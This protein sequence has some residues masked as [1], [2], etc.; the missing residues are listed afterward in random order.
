MLLFRYIVIVCIM[1]SPTVYFWILKMHLSTLIPLF[2]ITF[3]YMRIKTVFSIFFPKPRV[4]GESTLIVVHIG[5]TVIYYQ[6]PES[7]VSFGPL[8]ADG[9]ASTE[10]SFWFK[11]HAASM[12]PVTELRV[13]PKK[14][15]RQIFVTVKL[16][17]QGIQVYPIFG[18]KNLTS[19]ILKPKRE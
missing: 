9:Q 3:L 1:F 14:F 2:I 4:S 15:T 13:N 19:Y 5:D 16:T 8:Q 12:K 11:H 18:M 7:P 6:A 10:F 17:R